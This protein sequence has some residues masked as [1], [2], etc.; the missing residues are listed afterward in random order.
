M[1]QPFIPRKS[2]VLRQGG[3]ISDDWDRFLQSLAAQLD[4]LSAVT[5]QGAFPD[6]NGNVVA[7]PGAIY[8]AAAGGALV[9]LWVKE[10]G[11]NDSAGWVAK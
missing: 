1:A 8:T 11:T 10:S 9:T 7:S 4:A 3:L 2:A 5:V 6:P